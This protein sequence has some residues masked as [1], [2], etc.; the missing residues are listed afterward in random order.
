[1]KAKIKVYILKRTKIC[2]I[3]TCRKTVQVNVLFWKVI[4]K[5]KFVW[6]KFVEHNIISQNKK[7]I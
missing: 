2:I 5:I 6:K 4:L 1:M 3:Q 7:N